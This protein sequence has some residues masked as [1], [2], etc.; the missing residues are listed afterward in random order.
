MKSLRIFYAAITIITI[1]SGL[2][3][4]NLSLYLYPV[5][6][7]Y[8]GDAL[9]ASM[10]YFIIS[11]IKPQQKIF[12]KSAIAL[13]ICYAIEFSQLYQTPWINAIR[14]TLAGRLVL[15][16]GFLYSDLLAYV[17]GVMVAVILDRYFISLRKQR[18]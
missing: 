14:Q 7:L 2:L 8:A 16:S 11:F 12:Y 5:V 17:L 1:V 4:R 3:I 10:I 9:Y 18:V 15:G 13:I 6:N